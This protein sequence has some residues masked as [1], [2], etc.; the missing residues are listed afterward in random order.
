MSRLLGED[1]SVWEIQ[2][3]SL[4]GR[5]VLELSRPSQIWFS[6]AECS[7]SQ[8]LVCLCPLTFYICFIIK[9]PENT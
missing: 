9:I 8:C 5:L 3:V 7:T 4:R 6:E 1:L 2:E